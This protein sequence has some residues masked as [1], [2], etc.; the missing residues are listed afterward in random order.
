[1][2]EPIRNRIKGHCRVRA[3]DLVPH[4][5]NYRLHPDAQKGALQ[6]LYQEVGFARSLLAYELPDGRLKLIDGHLRREIDP[7]MEVEVE[8]LDVNEAEARELLLSIDPL[9]Q[10]GQVQEQLYE[11]LRENTPTAQPELEAMWEQ[12]ARQSMEDLA[13]AR[14]PIAQDVLPQCMLLV[15]CKDEKQQLELLARFQA[16]GLECKCL[17]S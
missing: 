7:D 6:A 13:N 10:M 16:D 17:L 4:E 11:R 9:V 8:I 15:M 12:M 5:W 14:K 3:G 1:M 2:N